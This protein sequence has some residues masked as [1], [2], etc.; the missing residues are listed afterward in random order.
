VILQP[1]RAVGAHLEVIFEH[2]HLPVEHEHAEV[3]LLV[4]DAQQAVDQPHEA[5]AI[6]LEGAI[7]GAVPVRMAD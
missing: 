1:G 6:L 3:G 5:N 7:P 4:E 2:A